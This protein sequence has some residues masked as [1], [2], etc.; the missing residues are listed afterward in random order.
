VNENDYFFVLYLRSDLIPALARLKMHYFTHVDLKDVKIMCKSV[1]SRWP[2]L[3]P[4]SDYVSLRLVRSAR[5]RLPE[6]NRQ[7]VLPDWVEYIHP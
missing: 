6:S 4:S 2:V 1:E 5:S 7:P 3:T